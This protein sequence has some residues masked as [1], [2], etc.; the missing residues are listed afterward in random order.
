MSAAPCSSVGI[1][2]VSSEIRLR[3]F[4]LRMKLQCRMPC[5]H[6][7]GIAASE[8][9]WFSC[10]ESPLIWETYGGVD[11]NCYC[12]RPA[13]GKISFSFVQHHSEKELMS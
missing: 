4:W 12:W 9:R 11:V 13:I 8:G 1:A 7:S 10:S 6:R 5:R 3:P 2:P